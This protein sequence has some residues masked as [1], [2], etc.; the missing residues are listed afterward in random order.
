MLQNIFDRYNAIPTYLMTYPVVT[1]DISYDVIYNLF[2]SNR[3]DIGMHCHPWNTPPFNDG[4]LIPNDIMSSENHNNIYDKLET[5]FKEIQNRFY[6][7]PL[8]FRAGRWKLNSCVSRAIH[9]LGLRIDT[10]VT[11][12]VSW[13]DDKGPDFFD[14]PILPYLFNPDD[15]LI[16]KSRGVLLEIPVT[17]G[18]FQ[19]NFNIC[20]KIRRWVANSSLSNWHILGILDRI[21]LM[22]LCW[23]SPELSDSKSMLRLA[24]TF[25]KNGASCLNLSFHSTSL[26]PGINPFVKNEED[27]KEFLGRIESFIQYAHESRFEFAPLSMAIEHHAGDLGI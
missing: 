7:K 25:V 26:L 8:S 11:P 2:T 5:L 18:F 13:M 6:C 24:R 3:C 20:A 19:K 10:S 14:A 1:N 17:I 15:V 9:E 21:G 22:N 23:L 27:L 4:D 12:F 16:P